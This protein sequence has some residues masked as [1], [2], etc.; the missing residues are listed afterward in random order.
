MTRLFRSNGR[1]GCGYLVLTCFFSCIFLII[2]AALVNS[3]CSWVEVWTPRFTS[4]D[5]FAQLVLFVAPVVM[6]FAEWWLFDLLVAALRS[7]KPKSD[8]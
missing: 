5:H 7:L 3:I 1:D 6:V 8:T 4:R 2:N